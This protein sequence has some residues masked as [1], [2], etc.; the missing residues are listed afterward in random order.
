MVR[1]GYAV[2]YTYCP[3]LQLR[4]SLEVK[5]VPGLFFAGQINGTSGYEEAAAQGIVAGINAALA[6]RDEPPLVFGRDEA[7]VGVLIDDLVTM[8]HREPYRMFTSRAEYRLLLRADNADLRLTP[9]GRCVGLVDDA[10]WKRFEDHR[11]QVDSGIESCEKATISPDMLESE[12]WMELGL[13]SP[14]QPQR[15]ATYVSRPDVAIDAL[16]RSG[17]VELSLSPRAAEQVELAF[18]Y[19]GYIEKQERQIERMKE[20]ETQDLPEGVNYAAVRGLRNE[21]REKLAR[22]RPASIGQASR[23]AGVTPA[24]LVVLT[25]H[26]K[27][28]P[29]GC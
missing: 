12:A 19:A 24:D 14:S 4:P 8:E 17:L 16:L 9:S 11:S 18:K 13:P 26:L 22:F 28:G 27:W 21:A 10:R 1:P 7:Y 15:L 5:T 6:L 29:G 20:L 25:V 23:I 3:P 2:E